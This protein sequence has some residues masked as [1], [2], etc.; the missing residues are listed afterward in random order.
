MPQGIIMCA[1]KC[2]GTW[3]SLSPL[4]PAI[5]TPCLPTPC[6]PAPFKFKVIRPEAWIK[7][8]LPLRDGLGWGYHMTIFSYPPHYMYTTQPAKEDASC[9]KLL[10]MPQGIIMCADKLYEDWFAVDPASII[11]HPLSNIVHDQVCGGG[12]GVS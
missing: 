10:A 2:A 6:C 1:A 8:T 4:A 12:V 9:V 3:S 5:A 11:G 7:E